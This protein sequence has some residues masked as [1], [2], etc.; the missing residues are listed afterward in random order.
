MTFSKLGTD[1]QTGSSVELPK[2]SRVQGLYI[3]GANGTGKST[4]IENLIIQDIDQELGLCLLD[5]HGDLIKA[6]L[7][8]MKK[9]L[10]DVILLDIADEDHP[11]GLNLYQ[12]DNPQSPKAVQYVVNQAMHVF[13]R[14]YGI[15]R[16]TPQ[17]LYYLRNCTYTIIANPG[18]TMAEIPL[19]LHDAVF[20]KKLVANVRES[21]VQ[22]F[23]NIYENMSSNHRYEE[24]ASIINKLDEFLQP[25]L[26]NI[27]G[28]AKT[29]INMREIMDERK[30]LLVKLDARLEDMTSLIGSALIAQILNAAYSRTDTP[31]QKRKQF[32]VYADEF[33]WF[34]TKDFAT[35]LTEARKFGIATTIAHQTR[36]QIDEANRQNSL[37][38]ANL[39]MFRCTAPDAKELAG[40]FDCTPPPG[41]PIYEKI[42][43]QATK[44]EYKVWWEPPEA[45]EQCIG[46]LV[47]L[48]KVQIAQSA[49]AVKFLLQPVAKCY[50]EHDFSRHSQAVY[51]QF[52]VRLPLEFPTTRSDRELT[53]PPALISAH[54]DAF[55]MDDPNHWDTTAFA[56]SQPL[57]PN[58]VLWQ[59]MVKQ[60]KYRGDQGLLNLQWREGGNDIKGEVYDYFFRNFYVPKRVP[61]IIFEHVKDWHDNYTGKQRNTGLWYSDGFAIAPHIQPGVAYPISADVPIEV[62]KF[63]YIRERYPLQLFGKDVYTIKGEVFSKLEE[64]LHRVVRPFKEGMS[65]YFD[66]DG[67]N[68]WSRKAS[69]EHLADLRKLGHKEVFQ[70]IE[71]STPIDYHWKGPYFPREQQLWIALLQWIQQKILAVDKQKKQL[72]Q[73]IMRLA[74]CRHEGQEEIFLGWSEPVRITEMEFQIHDGAMQYNQVDR[75]IYR[76]R[77]GPSTMTYADMENKVANHLSSLPNHQASIKISVDGKASEHTIATIKSNEGISQSALEKRIEEIRKNSLKNGY[78][79][80]ATEVEEEI[81]QRQQSYQMG[82]AQTPQSQRYARQISIEGN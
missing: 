34:A 20:R 7:S 52:E 21:R 82:Q 38:A 33:Q 35:L 78:L 17:M 5:P 50:K 31:T 27:I 65:V 29:T 23:W 45:E 41:E 56:Y 61:N 37:Q 62:E 59:A 40:S 6:I 25:L 55:S 9:R 19:L 10:E 70:H 53:Y 68:E 44:T 51:E 58:S 80:Q 12:C 42:M 73:T 75:E 48:A 49:L 57:I 36:Q 8:R 13:E 24:T 18:H 4:L 26:L 63:F 47:A 74:A 67:Y 69:E 16:G 81:I 15:T 11:F 77:E 79:R 76:K 1:I 22:R 66:L 72:M 64:E 30:I 3:I 28:Q 71:R 60:Y 54:M 32:N 46:A 2:A 43:R 39:I 14:L